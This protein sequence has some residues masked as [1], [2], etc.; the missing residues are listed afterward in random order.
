MN[1]RKTKF[2]SYM[3]ERIKDEEGATLMIMPFIMVL[4]MSFFMMMFNVMWLSQNRY[5][6]QLMCDSATRAGTQAVEY[7]YA[8]RE[9]TGHGY[10][11]YHVYTEL[12]KSKAN[13]NVNK[14]LNAYKDDINGF[15]LEE[16]HINESG[17]TSPVWNS[18]IFE[19]EDEAIN[20][21]KQY[22]NGVVNLRIKAKIPAVAAATYG[23]NDTMEI[24]HFSQS[25]ARGSVT[26]IR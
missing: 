18:R 3:K 12:N 1:D 22:Q 16:V 26:D 19:Y 2:F 20:S 24:D 8:V 7:S 10:G 15:T 6:V 11:D 13:S 21:E 14:I 9:R 5:H 17:T 4:A 23:G 25:V